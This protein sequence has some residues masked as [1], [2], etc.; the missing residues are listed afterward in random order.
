[1]GV[2]IGPRRPWR[3][4]FSVIHPCPT[5]SLSFWGTRSLWSG[6]LAGNSDVRKYDDGQRHDSRR[7][8]PLALY[9][10]RWLEF[11]RALARDRRLSGGFSAGTGK[12]RKTQEANN[13]RIQGTLHAGFQASSGTHDQLSGPPKVSRLISLTVICRAS[14][15]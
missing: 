13:A 14:C 4:R 10:L 9:K 7:R 3:A 8:H 15:D 11:G 12:R 1:M 5:S 6:I 2:A